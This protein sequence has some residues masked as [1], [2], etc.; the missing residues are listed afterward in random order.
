MFNKV[1]GKFALAVFLTYVAS[2]GYSPGGWD[3]QFM[4]TMSRH[5]PLPTELAYGAVILSFFYVLATS[6]AESAM[7]RG[8]TGNSVGALLVTSLVAS[9]AAPIL[10]GS[11]DVLTASL[12][13]WHGQHALQT[14]DANASCVVGNMLASLYN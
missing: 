2:I 13:V 14:C 5:P 6:T 8:D 3:W 9:V 11:A 12:I 1:S 7:K 4:L 10:G